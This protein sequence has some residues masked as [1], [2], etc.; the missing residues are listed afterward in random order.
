[1]GKSTH[2]AG[3]W[4]GSGRCGSWFRL[5][6]RLWR[7]LRRGRWCWSFCRHRSWS[8]CWCRHWYRNRQRSRYWHRCGLWF[9]FRFWWLRLRWLRLWRLR[10]FLLDSNSSLLGGTSPSFISNSAGYFVASRLSIIK[11]TIIADSYALC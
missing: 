4:C 6:R 11:S 8:G 7:G 10:L 5:W 9:W 2:M 1:M 3:R